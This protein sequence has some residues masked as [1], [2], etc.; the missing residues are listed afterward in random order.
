MERQVGIPAKLIATIEGGTITSLRVE[1]GHH[2][3]ARVEP[4]GESEAFWREIWRWIDEIAK[5]R[6]EDEAEHSQISS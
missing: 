4:Q 6:C 2:L 1:L 5:W 3:Y